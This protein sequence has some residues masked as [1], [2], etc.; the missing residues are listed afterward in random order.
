MDNL[1]LFI[2]IK[3]IIGIMKGCVNFSPIVL[4]LFLL[5]AIQPLCYSQTK[6]IGAQGGPIHDF[7]GVVKADSFPI[8][9]QGLPN[10]ANIAFGISKICLNIYHTRVSDL[11]V[12]LVNPAGISIWLTNR[13]GRDDGQHYA[14]TCFRS[15]GFSG[16]IHQGKAPFEGEYIP[17]GRLTF[18]NDGS[19][20][21]GTWYLLIT[22]LKAGQ[23][24]NLNFVTLEF[25]SDP[26]PNTDTSPCSFEEPG[27]CL[28]ADKSCDLLPDLIIL[29]QFTK[30]QIREYPKDDRNYPGQLRFAATIANV[31]DGPLETWG[32]HEWIC[33]G[34]PVD[35]TLTCPDGSYARQRI[36][37][38]LYRKTGNTLTYIDREAGTNYYDNKPGH[39]HYH[40]DDWVE[41]RLVKLTPRPSQPPL[42]QL[43]AKGRKVSYCL[44][45]SG[46]CNN[47]DS[48]CTCNG[49]IYGEKNLI[50]YGLG[51]Y[52]ECKAQKQGISVGGYDTYGMMYEGQFI[53]LPQNLPSGEYH[54]E[55]EIDPLGR[56]QEQ[57]KSNNIYSI[58]ITLS[59]Q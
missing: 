34:K 52:S 32:K 25:S 38:R 14:S 42:R 20:P 16:Y 29:P 10:V 13:N 12:E 50:N 39:N 46:I 3:R 59:K 37:Q 17:D 41:F 26:T 19:N 48:L 58:P 55:I 36:Y 47:A 11:K 18:L 28:C 8:K 49:R 57:D 30:N 27:G 22:D 43:I 35:S 45:D 15:N 23:R 1:V 53:Q 5:C 44:F 7:N 4:S 54:L 51:N 21:N 2:I 6:I 33:Q 40:V 31:G 9:V 24:G 56:I